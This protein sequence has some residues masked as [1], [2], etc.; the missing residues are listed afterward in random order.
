MA[1]QEWGSAQ[2]EFGHAPRRTEL[3]FGLRSKVGQ[4]TSNDDG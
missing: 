3:D 2:S 1:G 4:P